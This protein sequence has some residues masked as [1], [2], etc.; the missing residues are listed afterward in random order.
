MKRIILIT[1]T[2]I[3]IQHVL[4]QPFRKEEIKDI[5]Q[6]VADWQ[7]QNYTGK[8]GDL[9]WVNATFY[10]GLSRWDATAEKECQDSRYFEWL[11]QLGERN[12]W[13][14]GKRMYHADDICISQTYLELYKETENKE[15][16]GPTLERMEWVMQNPPQ[17]TFELDYKTMSN[18]EHWTW[19]DALFMAPPAY[20][21]M[22]AITG[23]RRLT[24][25]AHKE[26]MAT[27]DFL[28]DKDE[29][30]FYRDFRY[31]DKKEA[32]GKKIFWGRGN[33]WV[34]GGLAEIL[35]A[36]PQTDRH[37]SFYQELFCNMARRISELQSEDGFWRASLLD[38]EAYP[39]PETSSTGFFVYGLAYG[40]NKG[41][42]SKEEFMPIVIKGW[43]ALISAVEESGKLGYV[44]P[45]GADPRK[46]TSEMTEVYGPGAF[47]LAGSEIYRMAE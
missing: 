12:E 23:D 26:F 39:T 30:L 13:Q 3:S 45:I 20:F 9:N 11:Q 40:I 41:I 44:Q 42:L 1:L 14:V 8:Y 17:G 15:M 28:F 2:C 21:K 5:A 34:L 4:A 19:C 43:N 25:F 47:L 32:N 29:N 37:Y 35:E 7:I 18:L 6:K 33:G 22:A 27:Y 16:L 38:P 24:K 46:V 31:L 10:L 36:L